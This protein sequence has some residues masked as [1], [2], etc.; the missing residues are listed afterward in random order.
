VERAC[1]RFLLF[2]LADDVDGKAVQRH[3]LGEGVLCRPG[4]RFFGAPELG[5]NRL[6][7]AF[8]AA[9]LPDL[10]RAVGVL[11]TAAAAARVA[12]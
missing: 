8:T 2:G 1:G 6:R 3:A 12:A 5:R 7:L 9:P 10:E 4:E 11:G